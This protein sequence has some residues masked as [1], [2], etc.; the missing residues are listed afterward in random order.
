M[1]RSGYVDGFWDGDGYS[2]GLYRNAVERSIKGKRGQAFLRQL[3]AE[4]DAMP[5]KVLIADELVNADGDCCTMG[6]IFKARGIDVS[7]VDYDDRDQV[8]KLI[9]IA[10]SMAA[11][12]AYE[13]DDDFNYSS[14]ETP[15]QRWIR[16]R[17]WVAKKLGTA[18]SAPSASSGDEVGK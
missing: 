12:I 5:E 6:V 17:K 1:G 15:E 8:A 3:A 2:P 4:M 14:K 13:N 18:Y 16:M 11:E 9:N 10:P 7:D